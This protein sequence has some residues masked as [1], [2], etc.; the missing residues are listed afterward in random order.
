MKNRW[1]LQVIQSSNDGVNCKQEIRINGK[2]IW[3]QSLKC[4]LT[5][6]DTQQIY[7]TANDERVPDAE[8]KNFR[9]FTQPLICKE[10]WVK[11]LS[12]ELTPSY[13]S[14]HFKIIKN[15]FANVFWFVVKLLY[16][17]TLVLGTINPYFNALEMSKYLKPFM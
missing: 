10:L 2:S 11:S 16:P 13:S 3:S 17:F 5:M 8:V 6:K 1:K 4:P 14:H 15:A 9:F 7:L 12:H